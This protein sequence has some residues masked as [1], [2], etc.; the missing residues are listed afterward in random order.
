MIAPGSRPSSMRATLDPHG[1]GLEVDTDESP[2]GA[3]SSTLDGSPDLVLFAAAARERAAKHIR[4]V[5]WSGSFLE[6]LTIPLCAELKRGVGFTGGGDTARRRRACFTEL[7]TTCTRLMP[8]RELSV[9]RSS[10]GLPYPQPEKYGR[11]GA[12][13]LYL[14]VGCCCEHHRGRPTRKARA[15]GVTRRQH[16]PLSL[17][18]L[19]TRPDR[20]ASRTA[21]PF[22]ARSRA[23]V[24]PADAVSLLLRRQSGS[25]VVCAVE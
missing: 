3:R 8:G 4:R 25:I 13:G 20:A 24:P 19:E 6:R 23:G 14:S 17:S 12:R 7:R 15:S 18:L 21:T 1:D 11:N 9:N 2:C 16:P 5:F 22:G 10:F